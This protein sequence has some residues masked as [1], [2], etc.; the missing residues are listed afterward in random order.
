MPYPKATDESRL[1][2]HATPQG[3]LRYAARFHGSAAAGHF[4]EIPGGL[5]LSSIGIGTYLGEPDEATDTGY[6]D[7]VI[8]AVEGGF[9]VID[10]AIN[11]RFQRSERSIG[12]ALKRL[13]LKGFARDEIVLCTKAGFL[14]PDGDLPDEPEEYFA[15]EYLEHEIF[16][17]EEVAAGCHCMAPRYLENQL[18]R[19]LSN[20]GVSCVDVF[21]L[22]N[23]ETQI[24]EVPAEEFRRRLHDAFAF[25][26]SAVVAAKIGAYGL[27]TWNAF[28]ENVQ[29]PGFMSLP[30][31]EAIAREVGGENHHF[32]FLQLPLNLAMPEALLRPNQTVNA[33]TMSMVQAAR[34]LGITMVTSASLLQGQL[35]R[36][37]P[38]YMAQSLRGQND[39]ERALQFARSVP[40][41][42]TALAGMS[43]V[44]H[45]RANLSMVTLE[46]AGREEF[47]KLFEQRTP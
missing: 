25:M 16:R 30:E 5:V 46:P 22:H 8:A 14:S 3:T 41:V 9:N 4:R 40:G 32:R 12:A 7:S 37:L 47:L 29:S 43:H 13:A 11:Y 20:L 15:Q 6:T 18:D 45:V 27:A 44:E 38:P 42:T 23:P 17:P 19:S 28:R 34:A 2:G 35:T 39:A 36:N 24:S 33:K 31:V 21:Y 10:T 1:R 26:E